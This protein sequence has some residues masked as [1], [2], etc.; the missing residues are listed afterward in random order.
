MVFTVDPDYFPLDRMRDIVSYLHSHNQH[1]SQY[2]RVSPLLLVQ[3]LRIPI[4]LHSVLMTD[5][6]VAYQP[7]TGYIAYDQGKQL[8]IYLKNPN[9][10]D[11]LGVVWPGVTVFPGKLLRISICLLN[12]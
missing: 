8:D 11:N 5:P 3:V 1:Y 4:C 10:T 12:I 9:G 6:A 7:N 2:S